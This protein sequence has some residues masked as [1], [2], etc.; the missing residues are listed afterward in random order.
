MTTTHELNAGDRARIKGIICDILEIEPEDMTDTSRFKEDHEADSMGA[1]EI[2]SQLER[3]F[4]TD[5][6]QA[7]L[8]RMVN[9][10]GVVTVV[11]EAVAAQSARAN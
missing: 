9:L 7:E 6:D 3:A 4:G 11:G 2:L 5:I 8:S 1:I 10:D